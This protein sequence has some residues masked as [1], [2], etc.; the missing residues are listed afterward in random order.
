MSGDLADWTNRAGVVIALIGLGVTAPGGVSRAS[1]SVI[2]RLRR[3]SFTLR[4]KLPRFLRFLAAK[5]QVVSISSTGST[6]AMGTPTLVVGRRPLSA[7]ASAEDRLARLSEEIHDLQR[8]VKD[9]GTK[10]EQ[11]ARSRGEAISAL[12]QA[13]TG[14]T[15]ELRLRITRRDEEADRIDARGLWVVGF[16]TIMGGVP[17]GIANL[18]FN[19]GAFVL[20]LAVAA[21]ALTVVHLLR[22]RA[23]R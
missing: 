6:A 15:A 13:T 5:P 2:Q 21:T 19:L 8:S 11:E 20:A 3:L 14:E 23:R 18:P 10:L 9:M 12:Q 17:D 4:S 22:T 7:N 1:R 16:G